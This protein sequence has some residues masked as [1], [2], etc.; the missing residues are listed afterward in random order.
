MDSELFAAALER[1]LLVSRVQTRARVQAGIL[2][3]ADRD[4]A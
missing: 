4:K 2:F 3:P 1:S